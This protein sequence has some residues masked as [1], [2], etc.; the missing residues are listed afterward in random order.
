[1]TESPEVAQ[2]VWWGSATHAL[3]LLAQARSLGLVSYRWQGTVEPELGEAWAVLYFLDNKTRSN[4]AGDTARIVAALTS[5]VNVILIH[6]PKADAREAVR[7]LR[8]FLERQGIHDSTVSD[9]GSGSE[10]AGLALS[11]GE[12]R[13]IAYDAVDLIRTCLARARAP[14]LAGGV[15]I[16]GVTVSDEARHLFELAFSDCSQV[17]VRSLQGGL[18]AEGVYRAVASKGRERRQPFVVK[19][20]KRAEIIKESHGFENSV[21]DYFPFWSRPNW[22]SGRS[23]LRGTHGM[24]VGQFAERTETLEAAVRRDGAPTAIQD[25]F[26]SALYRWWAN[27]EGGGDAPLT[28]LSAYGLRRWIDPSLHEDSARRMK[29][30]QRH[31]ELAERK[32]GKLVVPPGALFAWLPTPRKFRLGRIHGDLNCR[33]VLVRGD[34]AIVIDFA[35]CMYGQLLADPAWL[36]VKL[37]FGW[38]WDQARTSGTTSDARHEWVKLVDR[39]YEPQ[40]LCGPLPAHFGEDLS[41]ELHRLCVAVRAIRRNAHAVALSRFDYAHLIVAGLVRL[42]CYESAPEQGETRGDVRERSARAYAAASELFSRALK[43][44]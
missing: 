5:G 10:L 9:A 25:L 35:N 37:V 11:G 6:P 2:A 15:E 27:S 34:V 42:S 14:R 22:L 29:A 41:D 23:F 31:R 12:L 4:W 18:C 32:F 44:S 7:A 28:S 1:M 36:E 8:R 33:N 3:P 39:L 17:T 40:E 26:S 21:R 20:A 19:V 16:R 30:V 38:R 43:D 13:E 24:L